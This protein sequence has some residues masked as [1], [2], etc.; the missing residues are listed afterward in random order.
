MV[1]VAGEFV[2]VE[3]VTV[4]APPDNVHEVGLNVP[5]ALLSLNETVPVGVTDEFD[6]S[7]TDIV[8]VTELPPFTVLELDM[9]TVLVESNVFV[10]F[11][12]VWF[13]A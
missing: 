10:E 9:I 4:Q 3:Y 8:S 11:V 1:T 12:L 2:E 5:A 6:V 13:A 7:A